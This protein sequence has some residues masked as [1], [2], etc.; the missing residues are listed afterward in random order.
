MVERVLRPASEPLQDRDR[1]CVIALGN[2]DG[3]HLGHVAVIQGARALGGRTATAVFEPHPRRFFAP[4]QP[5]FRLQSGPQRARALIE[6]GVAFVVEIPFDAAFAALSDEDFA[7][8][9]LTA[10]LGA[11]AVAI[12]FD[13]RFGRGRM[14]SPERLQQLGERLGFDVLVVDA[15][16]D[17][18]KRGD[19]VSSSRIRAA[20]ADGHVEAAAAMLGRPWAV[21]GVVQRGFQRGRTLGYPTLNVDLGDYVRPRFGVYATL[22]NVGD[23]LWRDSVSSLGVNPTIG[24]LQTPL[25]ETFVF[26]WSGDAYGR[27]TETRFAAF[28]RD[29]ARFDTLEAL[30]AQID[31]DAMDARAALLAFRSANGRHRHGA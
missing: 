31:R 2:F 27:T 1:G 25:L 29:E 15:V 23:G 26:D 24:A 11:R 9:V 17:A 7:A 5:P 16:D 4:H 22:T 3:V 13:F 19:K 20:L 8:E 18:D 12:G 10:Q 21:E 14:G 6:A 30:T 28:L